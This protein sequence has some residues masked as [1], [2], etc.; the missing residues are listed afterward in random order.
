ML[1]Q[2]LESSSESQVPMTMLTFGAQYC[3]MNVEGG[4]L[5]MGKKYPQTKW[6]YQ[7]IVISRLKV[8]HHK[9]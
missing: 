7:Q 5:V 4:R 3:T 9:H 2:Q 8:I 6:K 1:K